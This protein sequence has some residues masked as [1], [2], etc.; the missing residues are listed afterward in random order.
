MTAWVSQQ[1]S[2]KSRRQK[3]T[4]AALNSF[5]AWTAAQL[6]HDTTPSTYRR[7]AT[8]VLSTAH[9]TQAAAFCD[10]CA[11]YQSAG[12]LWAQRQPE[13]ARWL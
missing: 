8:S 3:H 11:G 12:Y 7:E 6:R 5:V 4:C 9:Q 10:A 1:Q 2:D 13:L